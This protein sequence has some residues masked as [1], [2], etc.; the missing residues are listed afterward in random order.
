[1]R[2]EGGQGT[3]DGR[4][5]AGET[6][7]ESGLGGGARG[8]ARPGRE[9]RGG[10]RGVLCWR[11]TG[12]GGN[13]RPTI[14]NHHERVSLRKQFQARHAQDAGFPGLHQQQETRTE[15]GLGGEQGIGYRAVSE[16]GIGYRGHELAAGEDPREGEQ[17]GTE[18]S[19]PTHLQRQG[20]A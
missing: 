7:Q 13:T 15:Q 19:R 12:R 14:W 16:Q 3:E 18:A 10:G 9:D 11:P 1:M 5:P 2:P 6:V 17:E 20:R 4:L 8:W